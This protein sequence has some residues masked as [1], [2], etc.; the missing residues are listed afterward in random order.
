M[1]KTGLACVFR[2]RIKQHMNLTVTNV[3]VWLLK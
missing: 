3:I 1:T 2:H